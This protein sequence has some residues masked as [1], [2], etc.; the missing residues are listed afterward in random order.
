MGAITGALTHILEEPPMIP[1]SR[2]IEP[3][4]AR[5]QEENQTI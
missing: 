1:I 4:D 3:E 2:K 5:D